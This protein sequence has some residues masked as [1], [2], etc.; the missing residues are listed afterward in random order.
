M[1]SSKTKTVGL[2]VFILSVFFIANFFSAGLYAQVTVTGSNGADGNYSQLRL[3]FN[4]INGQPNQAGRNI[5]IS[6]TGN[7]TETASAV[8]NQPSTSSWVSISIVPSGG[9]ARTI[10]GNLSA[11]VIDLNGADNVIIDGLNTGGNSLTISNLSTASTAGTSTIRFINDAGNNIIRNTTIEGSGTAAASGTIFFSTGT[12]T[13]NDNNTIANAVIRPAGTNLPVNAIYSAGT[14]VTVDN[15]TNHI[16]NNYIQDYFNPTVG[17][18]GVFLTSN[19]S[20]WTISNNRFFQ[21][22]TRTSTAGSTHRAIHILTA[23]GIDYHIINNTIGFAEAAG[24]GLTTYDGTVAIHFRAIEITV[25]SSVASSVQGNTVA[26]IA[27][28][29]SSGS[30]LLPGIFS[31][32]SVLVG[33]VNIGN[34]TPNIIGAAT[35]NG[36]INITSTGGGVISGIYV[37][38]T[39]NSNIQNNI[40]G[41]ISTGGGA[42]IGYTF[43]GII[44]TGAMGNFV[45]SGNLIGSTT[46][47][48]S[49][50]IGTSGVT[51]TGVC[52]FNGI[53]ADVTGVTTITNNTIINAT[54]Y[55]TALSIFRGI[56]IGGSTG[57]LTIEGNSIIAGTST[58]TGEFTVITSSA[59]ANFVNINQN[60]IR[61]HEIRSATA[62]F[63]A[64]WQIGTVINSININ[65]NQF[66]NADGGLV[67]YTVANSGALMGIS[68]TAG[69]AGAALTISGNDIRGITHSVA[70]SSAHTYII[71]SA[72]TLSQNIS[73]NTFTDLTI[74][75]TGNVTFISNNVILQP[76]GVQTISNNRI[77]GSFSKTGAGGTITLFNS[78][79]VLSEGAIINHINNNFSNITATGTTFIM[80]WVFSGAG[81]A[82]QT[83]TGNSFTN[84]TTGAASI[85]AMNING[86]GGNS[87]VSNNTISGLNGQFEITGLA[88]GAAG[89]ATLLAINNNTINNLVSTG[90]GGMVTG[91]SCANASPLVNIHQNTIHT[92]SSTGGFTAVNAINITAATITNVTSNYIQG[93]TA[94]GSGGT[95]TINGILANT[96]QTINIENNNIHGITMAGGVA[97]TIYI[98]NG[99]STSGTQGNFTITGNIIGSATANS[100]VVGTSGTSTSAVAFNG[101]TNFASGIIT[102]T[103]NTIQNATLHSTGA[104]VYS[105]IQNTGGSGTLLITGN[106]IISGTNNGTG[107]FTG[108]SNS[109][110]PLTVRLNNNVLRNYTIRTGTFTGIT[111]TGSIGS[112]IAINNN[113]LG[114]PDGGLVNIA[115]TS[116]AAFTGISNLTGAMSSAILEIIGNDFRGITHTAAAS[117]AYTFISNTFATLEQHINNNTF[118]NLAVNTTGNITFVANN[119]VVQATGIQNV[120][121]NSIVGNFNK[122]GAGGILNLFTSTAASIIGAVVNNNNNN[123]SNISV[124]GATTIDGWVNTDAGLATKTIRGNTFSNWTAGTGTIVALNVGIAGSNNAVTENLIH[125]LSTGGTSL[126]GISSGVDNDNIFGNTIHTLLSTG[127]I[128]AIVTGIN[129]TAGTNKN[130]YQNTIHNLQG[131][132]ITTGS[133]N[134]IRVTGGTNNRVFQNT[135]HTLQA[136]ALTTGSVNG[137]N[138]AG[139]PNNHVFQNT[140]H[141]LQANALTSGTLNGIVVSSGVLVNLSQNK[142]YNLSSS[143]AGINT[144][145]VNGILVSG[146]VASMVTNISNN[147][148]GDL[149]ATAASGTNLI[150]GVA[151]TSGGA[152]SNINLYYNT[153]FLSA[154]TT[155]GANLGTSG[156]F[157]EASATATTAR[158]DMRNNI[159]VNTS[160]FKGT[161]TAVA[162]RRSA[163][164]AGR[165]ANYAATSNNNLFFAGTPG[166]SRLIYDDGA[167]RAQTLAAYRAGVFTAGT[168]APRDTVSVSENPDWISTVGSDANYLN[169]NPGDTQIESRGANIAGITTDFTGN[170]RQGNPGYI[171]TGTSPDI[172][173]W[174]IEANFVLPIELLYFYAEPDFNLVEL[175]WATASETNNEYFIIERSIDI[176]TWNIIQIVNGAGN[177][178][179]TIKYTAN[180]YNPLNGISYYRLKQTDFDGQ[181]SYSPIRAVRFTGANNIIRIYPNPAND[182]LY[183]NTNETSFRVYV[184]NT[185]G[186]ILLKSY[187]QN[188]IDI[189]SIPDGVYLVKK[190]HADETSQIIRLVVK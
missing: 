161:G 139:G 69:T 114:N 80:G 121:G 67:T 132:V 125:T 41:S 133:V 142:I 35:G 70:G 106:S 166:A 12:V 136:N 79:A 57:V 105:G 29:T 36:S 112:R 30:T 42:A 130:I 127:V 131:N 6:I 150:M 101:I 8:L 169:I 175:N 109:A 17:S 55:G 148:I 61:N 10:D 49:I 9:A 13:G 168:I 54:V 24:T 143:S 160:E 178:S 22:A 119:V 47:A 45:I 32:I 90:A 2:R 100:I 11:P 152:A 181:Y 107:S 188:V 82:T 88:I 117:G 31:G 108:I 43:H 128:S 182:I 165:L 159:I 53:N 86:F 104:S 186:Q 51:T 135:I 81:L 39:S 183:I 129:I 173:A 28:S 92:L 140:I 170:I 172:G 14:S 176:K 110:G 155:T 40:I 190:I 111:N 103:G 50:A 184:I 26:G 157:H 120:N 98:F 146:S 147:L 83:I 96:N 33:A 16:T 63:R 180:D 4:A 174:E 156:V 74:N 122:T 94:S 141:T 58:G 151:L 5:T 167:D 84:W 145:S 48:H 73:N 99:I 179:H 1:D 123:F 124:A 153:I 76:A 85:T 52:A 19:S 144:G 59:A 164:S 20:N 177:S 60:I 46:T 56:H 71:N 27:F 38:N 154:P 115:A 163:G 95:R 77:T 138:V 64:V 91:L 87:S 102:I 185:L 171:G 3:A 93:L 23:S 72:A 15:S 126:I 21:T 134:G 65:N 162:F 118:T 149:S 62:P 34:I 68:N 89:N 189:S 78:T 75:T 25:G 66:G 18:N 37:I 137:I 97:G 44:T 158:L 7:T 116:G 187:N 113:Q